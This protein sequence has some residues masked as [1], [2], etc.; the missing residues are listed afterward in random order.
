MH[1]IASPNVRRNAVLTPGKADANRVVELDILRAAAILLVLACHLPEYLADVAGFPSLWSIRQDAGLLGLGLFTFVAGYATDLRNG[2]DRRCGWMRAFAT[3]R[4]FRLFPLYVPALFGFLTL[5][6]L[7]R[8]YH[9][10]SGQMTAPVVLTHLVAAQGVASPH[11][12]SLF[13]LWYVGTIV[14]YYLSYTILHEF[15][16]TTRQLLAVA[17][18]LLAAP[19]AFRSFS[20]FV[21]IRFFWY[22]ATF[23]GGVLGHRLGLF[24]SPILFRPVFL[25]CVFLVLCGCILGTHVTD[26]YVFIERDRLSWPLPEL[27]RNACFAQ[28]Y[29]A[30]G[31]LMASVLARWIAGWHAKTLM[32][33]CSFLSAV[34]YAVYLSHRLILA[35]MAFAAR[36]V[37]GL[38]GMLQN[39]ALLGIGIPLVF[40]AAFCLQRWETRLYSR[41]GQRA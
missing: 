29:L 23:V 18:L 7:L 31:I 5:F 16:S 2:K 32:A 4:L 12:K 19:L 41:K 25:A 9:D 26:A 20:G 17:F 34:A 35:P 15:S 3:K 39:V 27:L 37:W 10:I 1:H 21:D 6:G 28:A 33:V 40:G 14:L 38:P 24:S 36:D 13:T 8:V 30:S 22:Y 11:V